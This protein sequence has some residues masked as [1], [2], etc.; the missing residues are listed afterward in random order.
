MF[1]R[2][3]TANVLEEPKFELETPT[4]YVNLNNVRTLKTN[5]TKVHQVTQAFSKC[6]LHIRSRLT[7]S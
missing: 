4:H 5:T 3:V 7:S 1:V 6:L 2:F